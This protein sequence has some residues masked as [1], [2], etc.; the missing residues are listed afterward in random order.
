[1]K[2]RSLVIWT[3]II[4]KA[5]RTHAVNIWLMQNSNSTWRLRCPLVICV[6]MSFI[7][8]SIFPFRAAFLR[9][10]PPHFIWYHFY[11]RTHRQRSMECCVVCSVH[12]S[13]LLDANIGP[14]DTCVPFSN[15]FAC[16]RNT[17][18]FEFHMKYNVAQHKATTRPRLERWVRTFC[19]MCTTFSQE[20]HLVER[21]VK[22]GTKC[23][24]PLYM[25]EQSGS[26][27]KER[28]HNRFA[29][30]APKW[31]RKWKKYSER[32]CVRGAQCSP[33]LLFSMR[34]RLDFITDMLTYSHVHT[35]M[36][37]EHGVGLCAIPLILL[38]RSIF[39][40]GYTAS[41]AFAPFCCQSPWKRG[42]WRRFPLQLNEMFSL[43]WC[44]YLVELIETKWAHSSFSGELGGRWVA[45]KKGFYCYTMMN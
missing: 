30:S 33:F 41:S 43:F 3:R 16:E 26:Q 31:K 20:K 10:F 29:A 2:R 4:V 17:N 24:H 14:C 11:E 34:E 6:P 25:G 12:S 22:T 35:M 7:F 13:R 42:N 9:V 23:T 19:V 1:M 18:N 21:V 27:K 36:S 8:I 5:L 37:D 32:F 44:D 39:A 45:G 15:W 38:L 28:I 40:F